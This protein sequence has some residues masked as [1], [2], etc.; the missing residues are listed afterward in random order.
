MN[1]TLQLTAT[2]SADLPEVASRRGDLISD[3]LEADA[4]ESAENAL[5]QCFERCP[6]IKV[7]VTATVREG[8]Q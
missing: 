8:G 2:V 7:T 6:K 5:L 1:R 3:E 4:R